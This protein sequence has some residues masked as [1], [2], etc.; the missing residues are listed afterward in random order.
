MATVLA[1]YEAGEEVRKVLETTENSLVRLSAELAAAGVTPSLLL[2]ESRLSG[3][4]ELRSPD[5]LERLRELRGE[6][7]GMEPEQA[8]RHLGERLEGT[9]S[10]AEL[11]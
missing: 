4:E 6:L 7:A 2:A 8:A 10:N 5:Q 3:E 1:D 11:L 9:R